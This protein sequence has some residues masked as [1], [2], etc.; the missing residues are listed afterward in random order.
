MRES[1]AADFNTLLPDR[2]HVKSDLFIAKTT[3]SA[4]YWPEMSKESAEAW[5]AVKRAGEWTPDHAQTAHISAFGGSDAGR[6]AVLVR[7]AIQN[8][9]DNQIKRVTFGADPDHLFPG[10][11]T[12]A[13]QMEA[14][15]RASNFTFTGEAHDVERDLIDYH[16][17][18]GVVL[19]DIEVRRANAADRD[20]L[21]RFLQSTFPGR[22]KHDVLARFSQSPS[23]IAVLIEHERI[24][25][26]AL[27]QSHQSN[28]EPIAGAN[29]H[30]DLGD[31]WAALGPIGISERVRGRG[32]GHALLVWSLLDLKSQGARRTII[33]W[34]SLLDFYGRHGFEKSRT[35]RYATQTLSG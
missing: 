23:D 35:Y 33:D 32:W 5:V 31:N 22:W 6:V 27:T 8:L 1:L 28:C 11:P 18:D 9:G 17:P 25:G 3:G 16:P 13:P 34:T 12:D 30:L 15:L 29:W 10:C 19:D 7:E 20:D 21:A 14:I 26:F 24:E 2:Y 4:F